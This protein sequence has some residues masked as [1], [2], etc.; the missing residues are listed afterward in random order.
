MIQIV[1]ATPK[2]EVANM[3]CTFLSVDGDF[4]Q[5]GILENRLPIIM[6]ITS[7]YIRVESVTTFYIAIV[8]GILDF[9]DNVAT[10]VAQDASISDSLENALKA[11][12]ANKERILKENKRKTVDFV[13]AEKELVKNIK[14]I[15]ASKE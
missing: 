14:E 12:E 3:N 8:N 9:Q 6:K 7:S 5:V 1:V 2:G 10:V 13:Q 11:I 4:G 15:K